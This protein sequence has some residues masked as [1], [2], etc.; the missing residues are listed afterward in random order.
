M[1]F[2]IGIIFFALSALKHLSLEKGLE[3]LNANYVD[4]LKAAYCYWPFVFIPLYTIV[5]R[6]YGNLYYDSFNL[7]W[8]VALSYYASRE[9]GAPG[10]NESSR[11][12]S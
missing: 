4:G 9:H 7:L 3:G 1:P 2:R 12:E 11:K 6:H 8:A 5:P 10:Q